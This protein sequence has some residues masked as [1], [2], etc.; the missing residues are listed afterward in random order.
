MSNEFD[1]TLALL[2]HPVQT[3]DGRKV[4]DIKM[5][6]E[7]AP[8]SADDVNETDGEEYSQGITGVIHNLSG[9][10]TYP[11]YHNGGSHLYGGTTEADLVMSEGE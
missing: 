8:H 1:L 5:V 6:D 3:K 10:H 11:F 9:L 7:T 4:T 2:G